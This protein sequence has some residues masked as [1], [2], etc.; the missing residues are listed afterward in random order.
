MFVLD[1]TEWFTIGEWI[2]SHST[3]RLKWRNCSIESYAAGELKRLRRKIKKRGREL[4]RL[5]DRRR[6]KVR[7]QAKKL[8]YAMEFFGALFRGKKGQ[9]S[10]QCA[11][12]GLEGTAERAEN[13]TT[14]PYTRVLG[15]TSHE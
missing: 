9:A 2:T 15:L 13:S 12:A 14:L 7:I 5:S 6:H 8:G 10:S 3:Q 11:R 1:L 4:H